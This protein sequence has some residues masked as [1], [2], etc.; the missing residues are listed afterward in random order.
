MKIVLLLA[1]LFAATFALT[2]REYNT[3]FLK[4]QQEHGKVYATQV[5]YQQRFSIFRSNMDFVNSW[6]AEARGFTVEL[7]KFADLSL[8]E[9]SAM[10][11]GM[12]I[13]RTYTETAPVSSSAPSSWDWRTQGA[14]TG[15]KN[16][17]Q[18]GSCWSFSSTGSIEGAHYKKTHTLVSLSEQNLVDCS[19]AQGNQGCNG[20]LMDQAFQYVIQNNGIDTEESY[21]YT[22]T[23]PNQC[24]FNPANVGA[25]IT[26]FTDVQSGSESSL[27]NAVYF[28]P[29]SVAIDASHTSFQLYSSGVYYEPNCSSQQLDHGVLA[30]GYGTSNGQDYWIVKN[31]WGRS[32]GQQGYIWMSRNRGNNCGIATAASYPTTN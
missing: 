22:A 25:H 24:K 8:E 30:V 28:A 31:S 13:T 12:N 5:E 1:A 4:W 18:C 20:G 19:T 23:G 2:E 11:N 3:A 14:V 16:Q 21:P 9:F 26:G 7:N 10:Y 17:G 32:W 15:I 27:L 29:T 6:D